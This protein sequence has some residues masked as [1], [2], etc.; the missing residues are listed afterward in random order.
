MVR[1][2]PRAILDITTI[3]SYL[4]SK[5]PAGAAAVES[6]I[7]QT[8]QLL[9]DFP[10]SGR[11]VEQRR[12]VRVIPLNRYPYLVFYTEIDDA[13]LILHIRHGA[14]RPVEPDDL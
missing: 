7:Q 2:S 10:G 1:Y 3:A 8:I 13:I 14:R 12:T 5:S 9:A 4:I 11:T 6:A